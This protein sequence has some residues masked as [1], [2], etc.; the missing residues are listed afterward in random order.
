[1]VWIVRGPMTGTSKRLSWAGLEVLT[2]TAPARAICPPRAMAL[3]RAFHRFNGHNG[4]FFDHHRLADINA[5]HELGN[6]QPKL[7]VL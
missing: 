7:N 6:G 2:T 1:M 4:F 5:A 3:V